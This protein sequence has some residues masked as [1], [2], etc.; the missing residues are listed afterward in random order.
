MNAKGG[1]ANQ[2]VVY[3]VA[4]CTPEDSS[5]GIGARFHMGFDVQA[6]GYSHTLVEIRP[7]GAAE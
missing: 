1:E 2:L 6:G 7:T 4:S 5:N 3:V